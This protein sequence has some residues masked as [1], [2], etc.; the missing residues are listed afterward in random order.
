MQ[1]RP[2]QLYEKIGNKYVTAHDPYATEGLENGTW[3]VV[4]KPGSKSMRTLLRPKI[5]ELEAALN[6]LHEGLIDAI[7]EAS[8][9]RPSSVFLSKKEQKAW[10]AFNKIMGEDKVR[11]FAEF[12]SYDEIARKGCEYVKNIMLENKCNINKIKKKY[13]IKI[14]KTI[15]A[16]M[17]LEV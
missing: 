10:K 12:A 9:M 13:G 15:S 7:R 14:K 5:S 11:Y 6:Y 2:R 3:L 1:Y 8:E 16:I 4:V 17:D